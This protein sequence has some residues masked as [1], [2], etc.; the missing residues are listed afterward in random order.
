[1]QAAE[2]TQTH[3]K[4]VMKI[5]ERRKIWLHKQ[6]DVLPSKNWALYKLNYF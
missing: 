6:V 2:L 1:M 4:C 3:E 5:K